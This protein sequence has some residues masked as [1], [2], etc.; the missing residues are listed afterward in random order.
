[1][2]FVGVVE[3]VDLTEGHYLAFTNAFHDM[4]RGQFTW[5]LKPHR[6]DHFGQSVHRVLVELVY[7]LGLVGHVERP[8]QSVVLSGHA[9]W[10][11]IRVAALRLDAA[12]GKHETSGRVAPVGSQC[13]CLGHR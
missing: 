7:T 6:R 4:M 2:Q 9:N 3:R 10:A 11:S 8:L 5:V 12:D 13:H 1:M